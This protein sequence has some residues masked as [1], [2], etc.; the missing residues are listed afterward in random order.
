MGLLS[1]VLSIALSMALGDDDSVRERN[2]DGRDTWRGLVL[3]KM[4]SD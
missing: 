2:R 1:M 3:L 4:I